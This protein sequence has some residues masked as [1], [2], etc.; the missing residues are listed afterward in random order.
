MTRRRDLPPLR[1]AYGQ[2]IGAP[3]H[4]VVEDRPATDWYPW[5]VQLAACGASF[6]QAEEW[7]EFAG[8]AYL[9]DNACSACAAIHPIPNEDD[10]GLWPGW[11]AGAVRAP[12]FPARARE[13]SDGHH[14]AFA[15]WVTGW[16]AARAEHAN[17]NREDETMQCPA[18]GATFRPGTGPCPE[19]GIEQVDGDPESD[20]EFATCDDCGSRVRVVN[21]GESLVPHG[22]AER[23]RAQRGDGR[24]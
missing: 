9:R 21:G 12:L 19:C 5:G 22:C 23:R 13:E 2:R 16:L 6:V 14:P 17:T 20:D 3:F 7:M 1:W 11:T 10:D 4:V 24:S 15:G 8:R 18:C